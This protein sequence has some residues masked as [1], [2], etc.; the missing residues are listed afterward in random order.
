MTQ[1]EA[2]P[3][4]DIRPEPATDIPEHHA[5][6]IAAAVAAVF[7]GRPHRILRIHAPAHRTPLW[8]LAAD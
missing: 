8:R 4:P 6:L 7:N 3:V 2:A 1:N 5:V